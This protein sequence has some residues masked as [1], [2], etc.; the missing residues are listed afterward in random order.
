MLSLA[1]MWLGNG[2]RVAVLGGG[3][4]GSFFSMY[5]L[6]YAASKRIDL[7][8]DIYE[9]RSFSD[10][11]PKGCNRCA[12]IL[13]ASLLRNLKELD[14]TIPENVIRS[15]IKSYHLHSPFGVLNI[16]NPAPEADILSVFRGGGPLENQPSALPSFDGFLL[17][18]AVKKGARVIHRRVLRADLSPRPTL[19]LEDGTKEY[20][21]IVL[22]NGLNSGSVQ[23]TG[24]PYRQPAM[25]AMSQD[26]LFCRKEDVDEYFGNSVTAFLLPHTN[27]VF[28]SVVPKGNFLN[29]SLLGRGGPPDLDGFLEHEIVRKAIPF[30]YKRSCGCRPRI[31]VGQAVNYYADG[32]VAI[33]DAA[34]SRLYKDGIGSALL[35]ARQAALTAVFHGS[36]RYDFQTHYAP[37]CRALHRDNRIGRFIFKVHESTKN[38]GRFFRAQARLIN[39]EGSLPYAGQVSSKVLWGIFTGSYTYKEIFDMAANPRAT[40]TVA[41][42]FLKGGPA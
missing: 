18:Q 7:E 17:D 31:S 3:P 5:F 38:S 16:P 28:A 39:T 41:R 29:V 26:E 37:F 19:A 36:S 30:P 4:A 22:A 24:V 40:L 1:T 11:G 12:G 25:M 14:L 35:S 42:E 10:K 13:S 2:S 32:F 27:L 9:W 23:V 33:G 8:V 20:D 34:V 6:R 21:L 15:H